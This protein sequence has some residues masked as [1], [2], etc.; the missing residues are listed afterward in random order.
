M[1]TLTAIAATLV[2]CFVVSGCSSSSDAP[3]TPA[4]VA[5]NQV[6]FQFLE[7]VRVGNDEQASG[8]LTP[9]AR[10]QTKKMDLVV[11]PPG[12]DTA[13][14][15]VGEVRMEGTDGA[16]V[17][18]TWT[19]LD[20]NGAAHTDE[21]VWVLRLAEDGWRIAGMATEIFEG[22]EPLILNFEDPEDMLRKQR[23]AEEEMDRRAEESSRQAMNPDRETAAPR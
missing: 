1:R 21:I 19:D 16:Y 10:E 23:L 14:F 7:A 22:E 8:L 3:A 11:A 2:T 6:V 20:D 5:P 13:S 9:M 17:Q 18:C 12:S 4:Q 15:A